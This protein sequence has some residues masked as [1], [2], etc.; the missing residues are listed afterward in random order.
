M[1]EAEMIAWLKARLPDGHDFSRNGVT[2][3]MDEAIQAALDLYEDKACPLYWAAWDLWDAIAT[4]GTSAETVESETI[5]GV[6][7]YKG[8]TKSTA[9]DRAAHYKAMAEACET[10]D[11]EE[12]GTANSFQSIPATYGHQ[13]CLSDEN[14]A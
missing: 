3:T 5:G 6:Y 4:D 2:V 10:E 13:G 11:A 1:T 14:S 8:S 9:A 7:S 12:D